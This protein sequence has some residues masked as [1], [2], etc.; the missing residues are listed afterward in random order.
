MR[1]AHLDGLP[2]VSSGDLTAQVVADALA[3]K[4]AL[5][6]RSLLP[7]SVVEVLREQVEANQQ[8]TAKMEVP[9]PDT[10]DDLRIQLAVDIELVKQ[11]VPPPA[12]RLIADAYKAS[13]FTGGSPTSSASRLSCTASDWPS[14]DARAT[15]CHGTKTQ[16]FS[17]GKSWL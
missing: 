1:Y 13:G 6:V 5:V 10:P 17:V 4:G 14:P 2:E 12:L 8:E 15:A 3:A 11:R 9:G 16:P 7:T